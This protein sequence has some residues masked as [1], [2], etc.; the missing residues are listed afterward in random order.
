[1]MDAARFLDASR[2][3]RQAVDRGHAA[4]VQCAGWCARRRPARGNR[5]PQARNNSFLR[6]ADGL[7]RGPAS[8]VP[9]KPEGR[10]PPIFAVSGHGADVFCLLPLARQ[11]HPDQPVVG[12]QPPGLDGTEPLRID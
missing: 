12:V 9:L 2:P 5:Q 7:K 4:K 11:L 8:I 1:M 3:Q 10:R 6:Q